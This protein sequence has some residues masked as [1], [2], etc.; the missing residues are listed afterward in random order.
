VSPWVANVV[1]LSL[2]GG[3]VGAWTVALIW[4]VGSWHI[5]PAASLTF[6]E[7]LRIGVPAPEIAC[8]T[9]DAQDRHLSFGGRVALVVFGKAG[10]DPCQQ[11]LRVAPGHPATSS[12]R[13]VYVT[14]RDA[15]GLDPDLLAAWEV[16]EFHHESS[17]R[18]HWR[19][20][21]SPYFHVVD[22]DGRILEKGVA[23]QAAHLDRLL[24]LP[25]VALRPSRFD[26][27]RDVAVPTEQWRSA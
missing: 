26:S 13:R 12:M 5:S 19:A 23:N 6:D 11:L 7:G 3:I 18:E 22:V 24:S 16:Y 10:C 9:A 27:A 8:R 25:P 17:A 20:P 14:D 15:G 1:G 2:A 21:V 4:R